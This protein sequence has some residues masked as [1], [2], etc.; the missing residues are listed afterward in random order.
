MVEEMNKVPLIS[1]VVP[2]YNVEKYLSRCV[3]SLISQTY[4]NLEI[5]LV[6]DG[7]KD[8][9][10]RICDEYVKKDNRIKVIHQENKGLSGARNTGIENAHGEYIAFVDSDD[11]VSEQIYEKLL[12]YMEKSNADIVMCG[13][14][15]F[16]GEYWSGKQQKE[17]ELI[18]LSTEQ[19][20]E[21]IYS[22]D[23]ET[24]TVA[25]NKL[26][27]KAVIDDIRYPLRRLNEDEYTTYKY[28]ANAKK[29]VYTKEVLYYY[30]YNDNSITTKQNYVFN[31]DIYAAL[32]ERV[33][34]LNKR[35]YTKFEPMTQR[36]YLD[37]III[38]NKNLWNK[39]KEGTRKLYGMYKDKYAKVK[40]MVP[41]AG[42]K[43]YNIS[44]SLYY[45][46][47]KLKEH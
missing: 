28:I 1:V 12:N 3:E 42:Y 46:L 40:N 16:S 9:S 22:M 17:A 10:G 37:R 5:I 14:E 25:W 39:D 36:Q 11:Y 23:G 24:Y 7:A 43:I 32:E 2:V 38:R 21:N 47:L 4:E 8:N 44:P 26:Y 15:R 34:Y 45:F 29:I 33:Q 41:G 30:F 20:L 6:D 19:A 27:K 35:G 13:Y 31:T 18:E